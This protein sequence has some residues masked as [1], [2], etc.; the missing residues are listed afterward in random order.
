MVKLLGVL[1]GCISKILQCNRYTSRPHPWRHGGQ[2]NL[3]TAW[4]DKE[5]IRLAGTFVSF[6]LLLCAWRWSTN[7]GGGVSSEHCKQAAGYQSRHPARRPRLTLDHRRQ[8]RVKGRSNRRWDLREWGHC[9][10]SDGSLLIVFLHSL[11]V[12]IGELFSE[13]LLQLLSLGH[14]I[15]TGGH[16]LCVGFKLTLDYQLIGGLQLIIGGPQM[17]NKGRQLLTEDLHIITE[18]H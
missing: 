14:H 18:D 16:Q 8:R 15:L 12:D 4:E 6:Q 10:F 9:V 13:P 11:S 1:Q 3:T 2:M 5:F 7:F 17:T